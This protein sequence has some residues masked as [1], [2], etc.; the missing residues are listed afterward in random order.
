MWVCF[1]DGFVSIVEDRER[2]G[3]LLVRARRR[4]HLTRFAPRKITRS[5]DRD[6]MW[7]ASLPADWVAKVIA[8]NVAAIDYGNFKSSVRDRELHDMYA[9]W[10]GDHVKLQ[11]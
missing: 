7:R 6:Y 8:E 11:R 3:N 4:V 10:W 1:N 5:A 9:L 2:P